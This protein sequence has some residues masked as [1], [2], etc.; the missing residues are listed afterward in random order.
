MNRALFNW[1]SGKDSALCLHKIIHEKSY[2]I[3]SLLTTISKEHQRV[4]M[5]GVSRDLV[6]LQARRLGL[7]IDVIEI[8]DT[9]TT[10]DYEQKITQTLTKHSHNGITHSIFGDIFLED[11]RAYRESKLQ[12]VDIKAVFPLWNVSTKQLLH[13]FVSLGFKA[14][15]TS[16]NETFLDASFAGRIIDENFIHDLPNNIDPCGEHGEYHS[17]VFDGPLFSEPIQ[18]QKRE[19]I[20]KTY[21]VNNTEFGFWF[22]DLHA[23]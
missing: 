14:I 5:H 15:I 21:T 13:E 4:S 19:I 11:L 2:K 12:Q 22:C 18:I 9:G 20:R 8:S 16:V 7:P 3:E 10:Q 1:S 23:T 17:F 6:E